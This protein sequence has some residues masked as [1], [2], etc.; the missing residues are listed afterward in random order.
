MLIGRKAVLC[1]HCSSENPPGQKFCG[2]CGQS[3][4]DLILDAGMIAA[5][6]A[7]IR[8]AIIDTQLQDQNT[9]EIKTAQ[10]IVTRI[11]DWGKLFAFFTAIPLTILLATLAIWGVTSFLDFQKKVDSG[12]AQIAENIKGARDD[13]RS[14]TNETSR[15]KAEVGAARA[16]LGS[17]PSD[18]KS[19]QSKVANLEEKIGF[20]ATPSL[21]PQLETQLR[22]TLERFQNYC[23][24][25]GFRPKAG[26]VNV[27]IQ[28]GLE[29]SGA[30]AWYDP[31]KSEMVVDASH[32]SDPSFALHEYM[33]RTLYPNEVLKGG[34]IQSAEWAAIESGLASYFPASFLNTSRV[35]LYDLSQTEQLPADRSDIGR[36]VVW[37]SRVWGSAFW[38]LRNTIGKNDCDKLLVQFWKSLDPNKKGLYSSYALSRLLEAYRDSGGTDSSKG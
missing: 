13:I 34:S 6:D 32:A 26:D 38:E 4:Q 33:H 2:E 18:V 30:A 19:L 37:G 5:I 7:R 22:S 23:R 14:A 24:A 16:E 9:L 3:T 17:L 21:T 25:I 35:D 27:R 15:L 31:A 1:P 28:K 12:K 29:K 20:V 8:A 11:T 36:A 10:A